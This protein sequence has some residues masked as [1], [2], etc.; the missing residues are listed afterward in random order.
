MYVCHNAPLILLICV[1]NQKCFNIFDVH[2]LLT[3]R[4]LLFYKD[5]SIYYLSL[6]YMYMTDK[7]V[8]Y[9]NYCSTHL[10]STSTL[11]CLVKLLVV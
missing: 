8:R 4:A 1:N 9:I 5:V 2:V 7:Y 3:Q 6:I 11:D 10:F